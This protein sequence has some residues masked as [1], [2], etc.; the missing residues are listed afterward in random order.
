[1]TTITGGAIP[2]FRLVALKAGIR[3]EMVGMKRRGD[4]CRKIVLRE[5][6]LSKK[7]TNEELLEILDRRIREE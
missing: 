7:T 6:N 5:F 3:L 2:R 4:S 1:M